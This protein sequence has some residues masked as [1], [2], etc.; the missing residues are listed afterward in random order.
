MSAPAYRAHNAMVAS[1]VSEM[2]V[3]VGLT[4]RVSLLLVEQAR[5]HED[6]VLQ[7]DTRA[8][9][10]TGA[11]TSRSW[12]RGLEE[13]SGVSGEDKKRERRG[14]PGGAMG[15][16]ADGTRLMKG[17]SW[18]EEGGVL[19]LAFEVEVD[20]PLA[21]DDA[22]LGAAAVEVVGDDVPLV[23]GGVTHS[24]CLSLSSTAMLPLYLSM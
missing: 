10:R 17:G 23:G 3:E 18:D 13:E 19:V 8:M 11:S 9:R 5:V 22:L 16:V 24:M 7:E 6:T 2:E 20:V 4:R 15:V 14:A 12:R 1:L 21:V